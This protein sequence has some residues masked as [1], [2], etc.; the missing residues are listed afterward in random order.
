MNRAA[1]YARFSDDE[2]QD[3][4]SI[5]DQIAHCSDI[6]KREGLSVVATFEDRGISG[7]STVNRPGFQAMMRAAEKRQFD[8][9]IVE[10]VDR[11]AR[12]QADYHA[13]RRDLDF[14]GI[15]LYAASGK[16]TR[17]DGALR[18][19]M[20]EH[21][22]ENLV[23]HIKRG[24]EGVVRD[25]RHAGGRAYGY[26]LIPG[27]PGEF[28]INEAE[29]EIIREIF[30]LYAAGRSPRA[31]AGMLNERK[32]PPPRGSRWSSSTINGNLARGHGMLLNE[33]YVGRI[34]WNK[35]RMIKDPATGKRVS[36]PNP[37]SQHKTADAPQL[38]IIEDA[39]WQAAQAIK[40]DKHRN[41]PTASR[42]PR[43]P[44]SGLMKCAFCG[45]G[46]VSAGNKSGI[47]RLQCSTFKQSGSC[48]NNRIVN[49]DY[50][51]SLVF[52]G[53][54]E[55]LENPVAIAE[56]LKAYNQERTRLSRRLSN[57]KDK[58]ER[59]RGE[60]E[61]EIGRLVDAIA[62]GLD[63]NSIAP[64]VK[65]L[66]TERDEVVGKLALAQEKPKVVT[67]HPATLE[68]YRKDV[69]RLCELTTAQGQM[70]ESR[71]LVDL[72]RRLVASV[73]VRA[74]NGEKDVTVEVTGR[75]AQLTA[76]AGRSGVCPS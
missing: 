30:K 36:R 74:K 49:R 29:A 6:A 34:V 31:I 70:L 21:F 65:K 7:A 45:G 15:T 25:G 67:L 56:Y 26:K 73:I 2:L 63:I 62:R 23:V 22:L 50:V 71:E 54:R 35:V 55:E 18:A 38:R 9:V 68:R 69:T 32:V 66:E 11:F 16:V 64:A 1:I 60:I 5:A 3:A 33:M 42:E 19:L 8:A 14:I 51:E 28:E 13:A 39:L 17:M 43:R 75:L 44:L 72:L 61:R 57:D 24:L 10:D 27:K 76:F 46:M 58:L 47:A 41:K 52:N 59:R 53:L 12:A 20:G 37:P 4:R 48:G 40:R